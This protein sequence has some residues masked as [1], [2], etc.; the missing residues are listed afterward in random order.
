VTAVRRALIASL[1]IAAVACGDEPRTAPGEVQTVE[2]GPALDAS[3]TTA[4]DVQAKPRPAGLSGILPGDFPSDIPTY[5]PATLAD[6]GDAGGGR[7]YVLLQTPDPMA[8][9][10]PAYRA[11]LAGRGWSGAGDSYSKGGR[12]LA[13]LFEDA[14]PGTRIRVEYTP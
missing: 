3:L 10:A 7:R 9:A 13:V 11:A 5:K 4:G 14:R 6:F 8:R 2:V 1:V 12:T